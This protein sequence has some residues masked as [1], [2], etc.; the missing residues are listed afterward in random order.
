M[1]KNIA[2]SGI[3]LG[4]LIAMSAS[5][6]P[7]Y[8][9]VYDSITA[10][11]EAS[12]LSRV[13]FH[14]YYRIL[15]HEGGRELSVITLDYDP[16]SA[17]VEFREAIIHRANGDIE[18][19]DLRKVVDYPAPARAIY[20][21]ARQQMLPAGRLEP[22][23]ALE[24]KWFRKGFTYALLQNDDERYIPPMRGHYYD[25]VEFWSRV[26][27]DRKVYTLHL[28]AD[29][30]LQYRFYNGNPKV[31]QRRDG[32]QM[33]YR[34][35]LN[36]IKPFRSEPNMVAL[37][38]VAP[39]L[40]MSTSPDWE[41]KSMWFYKVNEDYGS[42]EWDEEILKKTREILKDAENEHDSI[43][44]LTH[45]V[46]DEIRYSGISMGEG[47]GF[48][49]HKGTMTFTDRCG[50]CKDKAGMLVTML[51]AA[52]FE[53][54]A[55]MTMAGSR[56][57]DIPAD[58][59]N[60]S[61]TVVKLKNGE[62][63]LLDPTWVPFVRE[64][65]SSAEQQ[66]HYLMGLPQGADLMETPVSPPQAHYIVF[67]GFSAVGE[68]GTLTG[69][70]TLR[71]EGQSDAAI[72][73]NFTSTPRDSWDFRIAQALREA[74][75]GAELVNVAYEDP[76]DYSQPIL[77]TVEYTVPRYADVSDKYIIFTPF[78]LAGP[79]SRAIGHLG[80]D[81]D[82]DTREYPFR[83]RCSRLL[84]VS[85]SIRVPEFSKVVNMPPWKES[86]GLAAGFDGKYESGEREVKVSMEVRMG[87][88]VYEPS[89]WPQVKEVVEWHKRYRDEPVILGR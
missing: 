51:R 72:R 44:R 48:T 62:Y 89:D 29:K 35:E 19:I 1:L 18:E 17:F 63:K 69:G 75:P 22:G 9:V 43:S 55:A 24:I 76:Y 71:A 6:A 70:F 49:L 57:E 86:I 53:S 74:H 4:W 80:F 16:L 2:R 13:S 81:T 33:I 67:D 82:L 10:R 40:V 77:L 88:R 3:L 73:R 5:A 50:V 59:F 46:A 58:Q 83:D 60:H 38:D 20:W 79:F 54:Y 8:R 45:W 15:T 41:A 66:Q 32:Q 7:G 85:E 87:K 31:E 78:L 61:V 39:K 64:L 34:W 56:I 30:N 23:D 37:S 12:G 52:G 42:F 25:I 65:W 27:V 36:D 47:E 26:P 68:D 84:V 11:V 14:Q 28:P 21:G